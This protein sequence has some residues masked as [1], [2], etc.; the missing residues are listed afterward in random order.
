MK[1]LNQNPK[2]GIIKV[3][4][5]NL[6]DLWYLSQLIDP[7]DLVSGKTIRKIRI[8]EQSD[9]NP[10]IVKKPV[11][12]T[13]EVE[14]VEFSK[15]SSLL[16][17]SGIVV[18]GPEDISRGVHHTFNIEENTIITIKKE[19]WLKFQLDKLKEACSENVARILICVHDRE[20]AYF[21][22]LKKS[23][24]DIL[25][26]I[27][28]IVQKKAD[29]TKV[30]GNFYEEIIRNLEEYTV[31]Y[32]PSQIILA[33]PAFWKEDL[34]KTL[35]NDELRKRIVIATCS[36]V[37]KSAI[38]EVLK[39][40]ET[41]H[42]LKQDRVAK[43]VNLVEVLL[44]EI[45]KNNLGVYGL[46]ETE[47]A[48]NAGAVKTLLITDSLITKSRDE[49][50]YDNLEQMMKLVESMKGEIHIINSDHEGGKKLNGLGGIGAILRYKLNY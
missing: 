3:K 4:V 21:A 23:G 12:I 1:A 14:K 39:R 20:E 48:V 33:S 43:E 15:T 27:K 41:R 17:V 6:D 36:S 40:E 46:K 42:A 8:G 7:K 29:T 28:G 11:F 49:N 26:H 10:K 2:K 47:D 32:K 9:R 19:R 24:Y 44:Q 30:T 5:E 34:M 35:K 22:L 38:N 16:R 37:G 45:S 13:M 25:S 50:T 18:E 31:R